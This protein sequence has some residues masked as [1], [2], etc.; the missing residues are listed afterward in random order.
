MGKMKHEMEENNG[1][2]ASKRCKVKELKKLPTPKVLGEINFLG[3]THGS[4]WIL[5]KEEKDWAKKVRLA[6]IKKLKWTLVDEL[7]VKEMIHSYNHADQYVK[8]KGRQINVGEGMARIFGLSHE[9]IV[10]IG[11]ESYNPIVVTYFIG[12]EDENTTYCVQ[13]T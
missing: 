2:T 10:P 11:K 7:V 3:Y 4:I 8:L 1:G 6:K 5:M 13:D 12:N 9:G